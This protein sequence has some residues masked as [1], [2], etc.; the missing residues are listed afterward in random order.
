MILAIVG[1]G[2][3][4]GSLGLAARRS[5]DFTV[6][7]FSP[8]AGQAEKAGLIDEACE[9]VEE[10]VDGADIVV[11][12]VPAAL[13]EQTVREV[14]AVA[15]PD[16]AVTDVGSTKAGVV[17]AAGGDERYV[18]GHPLAGS[19]VSGFEN[20][21]EGLFDDATWY[22]TPVETTSGVSLERVHRMV[23]S[24]SA[25]PAIVEPAEH[26]R[27]M[28]A[29]S[30]LPHVFANL[31]VEQAATALGDRT[32]PVAGPSF[33]DATRVAGSTPEL[34]A[35]IYRANAGA[36]G[37]A[38]DT[39]MERLA[40]VREALGQEDRD[41]LLGWQEQAGA[42][43]RRLAE[44]GLEGGPVREL[45]VAVPNRPGVVAEIALALGRSDVN[46][47][48]MALSPAA[49]RRSGVISLWVPEDQARAAEG[50]LAGIDLAPK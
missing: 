38:I 4:G 9:S 35:S 24:L 48:D 46:I 16:C 43:R 23:T 19:E 7:G 18:G 40:G 22:L 33:R 1:V 21:R 25:R 32:I 31:L 28:A 15:P 29:V 47:V 5:G 26:D 34:W 44:L 12:A 20:A 14:L 45:R 36:L 41:R 30:H 8:R 2:L 11:V 42:E 37:E 17:A 49:D 13:C 39:A 50:C 27:I 3:I 6:R 10:A